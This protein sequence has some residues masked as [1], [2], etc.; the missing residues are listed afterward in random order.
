MGAKLLTLSV[1]VPTLDGRYRFQIPEDL[2]EG[3]SVDLVVVKGV[4]PVGRARNEGLR[5][6]AGDYVAWVDADD[7][8]TDEWLPRIVTAAKDDVDCIV[9]DF[10]EDN[11]RQHVWKESGKGI[12]HDVIA[13]SRLSGLS[14]ECWRYVCRRELWEGLSFDDKCLVAEDYRLIPEVI[15]R[16]KTWRR[17]GI[18]YKYHSTPGSL[19][20][21]ADYATS[22]DRIKAGI[23][24]GERWRGTEWE[25]AA[26]AEAVHEAGWMNEWNGV[27][28]ESR[29]FIK[30]NFRRVICCGELSW[31]WKI[32]S[33]L[34][35]LRCEWALKP[36]YLALGK[37][38]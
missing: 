2:P 30:R 26:F 22:L 5:R 17:A 32:K 8:V 25:D 37:G 1:I 28:R 21:G 38:V 7:D 29:D 19:I 13:N 23:E 36:L 20:R 6:A 33:L 15:S 10:V 12:L 16:V 4:S 34:I 9:L 18:C 3:L 24:R 11:G 35:I 31:Q 14:S 27:K